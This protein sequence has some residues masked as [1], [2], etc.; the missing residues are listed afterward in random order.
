MDWM[1]V[2]MGNDWN[3]DNPADSRCIWLSA[4]TPAD[5]QAQYQCLSNRAALNYDIP[6]LPQYTQ[7]LQLATNILII[8]YKITIRYIIK[9][10]YSGMIL[11]LTKTTNKT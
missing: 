3:N 6:C 5:N 7:V 9:L 4:T 2:C 10:L 11:A 8:I 1:S